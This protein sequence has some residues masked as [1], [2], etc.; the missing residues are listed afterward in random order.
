MSNYESSFG[1]V[2][3]IFYTPEPP[4]G[5]PGPLFL[6][7]M[8]QENEVDRLSRFLEDP[9]DLAAPLSMPPWRVF[10]LVYDLFCTGYIFHDPAALSIICALTAATVQAFLTAP[11]AAWETAALP[12]LKEMLS[13]AR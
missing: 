13:E 8:Y 7:G 12:L 1:T 9:G 10:S 3:F 2:Y 6:A 5:T 4:A 11:L